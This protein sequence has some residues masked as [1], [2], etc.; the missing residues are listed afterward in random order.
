MLEQANGVGY[1]DPAIIVHICRIRA[2]SAT[3]RFREKK[4]Q[5]DDGVGDVQ[6]PAAVDISAL[7]PGSPVPGPQG[8]QDEVIGEG[9]ATADPC[10]DDQAGSSRASGQA[11]HA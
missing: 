10:R 5:Y 8:L 11:E 2:E 4:L 9:R 6:G 3:C 1:R 7:K